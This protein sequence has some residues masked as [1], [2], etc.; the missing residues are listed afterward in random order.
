VPR[1]R[2][3]LFEDS[4]FHFARAADR[5]SLSDTDLQL[6]RA[7]LDALI[8]AHEAEAR[9]AYLAVVEQATRGE[10]TLSNG[11]R[12]SLLAVACHGLRG[13]AG[14][15]LR[16]RVLGPSALL[17]AQLHSPTHT[18][19]LGPPTFERVA[20]QEEHP[21]EAATAPAVNARVVALPLHEPWPVAGA[22]QAP[23]LLQ[24]TPHASAP[25][26][27]LYVPADLPLERLR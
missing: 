6:R 3:E 2:W 10:V 22:G 27:L 5:L 7:R 4:L 12:V 14:C 9:A 24:L 1:P 25:S 11:A 26:V 8:D 16:L 19:S 13:G 17:R 23:L 21:D 20:T 18:S 15:R